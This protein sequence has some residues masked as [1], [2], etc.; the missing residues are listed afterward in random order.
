MRSF[1]FASI[2]ILI[3]LI[4]VAFAQ[5]PSTSSSSS[6]SFSEQRGP[7]AQAIFGDEQHYVTLTFYVDD[8]DVMQGLLEILE[9]HNVTSAVFFVDPAIRENASSVID[10]AQQK[11][12]D[13]H[14]WK[15]KAAF[16]SRFPPSKFEGITL[17]DRSV[18]SRTTKM[19]DLAA[20]YSLALHSD[21]SSIIAFTPPPSYQQQSPPAGAAGNSTVSAGDLL[22]EI[23]GAVYGGRTIVFTSEPVSNPVSMPINAP[24]PPAAENNSVVPAGS[25]AIG[26]NTTSSIVVDSGSWNITSL[27]A[28]YPADIRIISTPD[29]IAYLVNTTVILE[30]DAELDIDDSIVWIAS[31]RP[32]DSDRRIEAQGNLTITDSQISSW[33]GIRAKQDDNPY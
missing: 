2:M 25:N 11:D 9:E 3:L 24:P 6:S 20:L 13:V 17:S 29:G 32:G 7:R 31:P 16:D 18:I 27:Q 21:N 10:L 1:A 4:P 23:L 22:S 19:A 15:N 12:Y 30:K 5:T 8:P 26:T 28:R 14:D 33:D